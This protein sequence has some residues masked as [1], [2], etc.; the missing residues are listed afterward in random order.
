MDMVVISANQD[1]EAMA[2]AWF[3]VPR[4]LH[5]GSIVFQETICGD[6]QEREFQIVDWMAKAAQPP[7]MRRRAA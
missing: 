6:S 4:M 3:Y 2:K 5:P 1:P 7:A